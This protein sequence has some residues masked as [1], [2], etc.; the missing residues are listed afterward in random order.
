MCDKTVNKIVP[1]LKTRLS[2]K[3]KCVKGQKPPEKV[4]REGKVSF[5]NLI[6]IT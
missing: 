4:T 1:N 2:A 5:Q 3:R 6:V